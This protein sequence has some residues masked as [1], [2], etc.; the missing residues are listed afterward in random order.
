[1]YSSEVRVDNSPISRHF[2]TPPENAK[3]TAKMMVAQFTTA[4]LI[5]YSEILQQKI[6]DAMIQITPPQ[7]LSYTQVV[8]DACAELLQERVGAETI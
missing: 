2:L 7:N 5:R 4:E 8:L 3:A 6:D 1:M